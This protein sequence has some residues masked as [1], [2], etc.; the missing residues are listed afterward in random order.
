MN[1][2]FI[3]EATSLLNSLPA[4]T[5]ETAHLAHFLSEAVNKLESVVSQADAQFRAGD[6]YATFNREFIRVLKKM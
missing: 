2:Q 4:C 3:Q 6:S 1:K 5:G